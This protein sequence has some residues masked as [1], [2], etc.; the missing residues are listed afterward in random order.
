MQH[1]NVKPIRLVFQ[2]SYRLAAI[3]AAAGLGACVI[4]VC[5]PMTFSLKIMISVP[6]VLATLYFTAQDALLRLPWSIVSLDLNSK[7]ELIITD[8]RGIKT[9]AIVL[10]SSFVASYLTVLNLKL[11]S[12]I[13]RRNMILTPDRMDEDSFRQ[14]RVW[15]RWSSAQNKTSAVSASSDF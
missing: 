4:V 9:K 2:P 7:D 11:G 5:M 6:V 12:A 14:L 15:L 3:L 10:P 1:Y 13:W 8:K